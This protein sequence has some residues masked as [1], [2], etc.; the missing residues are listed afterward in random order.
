MKTVIRD[1]QSEHHRQ[2][3]SDA[4]ADLSDTSQIV[5]LL[6]KYILQAVEHLWKV[7]KPAGTAK[8]NGA[9]CLMNKAQRNGF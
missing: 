7:Q 8:S 9:R 6:S 5:G 3:Y 4:L 1:A 2:A